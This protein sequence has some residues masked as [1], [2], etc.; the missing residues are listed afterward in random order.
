[1]LKLRKPSQHRPR[2]SSSV[3]ARSL[4]SYPSLDDLYEEGKSLRKKCPRK[5]HAVWRPP[6]DRPDPV[7]LLQESNKGRIPQL[8]PIRHGRMM[9]T[10]FTFY[11]GAA[12]NMGAD[13]AST[14]ATGLHVQ[15]CGDAH[16]LN[17]GVFATPERR[18]IFDINDL[19]ETLPAP[20]EWDVKRLAASFVLAC[21]NNGFSEDC[22]RDTALSCVRSYRERLAEFSEMRVLDVWYASLD[23]D[24]LMPQISDEKIRRRIEKHL[25]AARKTSV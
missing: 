18:E 4:V 10:P 5:S 8:I 9:Q 7:R 12:L 17:F 25:A 16:L 13:L 15:A 2:R 1:M 6:H 19:D 21:R 20:W 22:A 24:E 11:R 14:P 3:T 23:V